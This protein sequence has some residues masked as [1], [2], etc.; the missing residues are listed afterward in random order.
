VK[1]YLPPAA[2]NMLPTTK[3]EEKVE[4]ARVPEGLSGPPERPHHDVPIEEFV[5]DQHRSK[6]EATSQL[7]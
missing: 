1:E 6:P 5:R 3:K 2:A 7:E 4:P